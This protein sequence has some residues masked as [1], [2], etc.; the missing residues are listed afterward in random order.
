MCRVT[1][2]FMWERTPCLQVMREYN[3]FMRGVHL[4]AKHTSFDKDF[5]V[6]VFEVT[7]RT[8]GCVCGRL[9]MRG[10]PADGQG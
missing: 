8:L 5:A 7:I 9:L 2:S 6:S 1:Q 3:E 10:F 4:V